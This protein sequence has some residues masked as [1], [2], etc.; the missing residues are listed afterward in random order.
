MSAINY[1]AARGCLLLGWILLA[2]PL[3][4]QGAGRSG[5]SALQ[6]LLV[7]EDARGYGVDG[8]TPLV[9]GLR[10][11]DSLFRRVAVR[12]IGRLQ[13]PDLAKLLVPM[14]R[15]PVAAV[16]AEAA[17][18]IAQ[19]LSGTGRASAAVTEGQLTPRAA[20]EAILGRLAQEQD[21]YVIDALAEALGR[22]PFADSTEARSAEAAMHRR[23]EGL[24]TVGIVRGMYALTMNRRVTGGL[25]TSGI[26]LLRQAALKSSDPETRR[27]SVLTLGLLNGLDSTTT[28]R[29]SR[30]ADE[31][32]RRLA[33]AGKMSVGLPARIALVQRALADPSVIVRIDAVRAAR[34]LATVPDCAPIVAATRDREPYVALIAIDAL[35]GAC[36]DSAAARAALA[37]IV[38]RPRT[39]GGDHSWQAPSRALL[40]LVRADPARAAVRLG[41]FAASSRWQER[42]VAARVAALLAQSAVL[43][44]LA[45]DADQNVREAAIAGL[46]ATTK[47]A[48]DS[49]F[50]AGLAAPGYQVVLAS[51]E[52]LAGSTSPK[53]LPAL[54]DA[55]DAVTAR[56]SENARDPRLAILQRIGEMG[57]RE[58][59]DRLLPYL[60]DFDTTVAAT[61]ATLLSKWSGNA[62]VARPVPLPIQTEPLAQIFTA[63]GMRLR[64]TLAQSSGGGSFTIALYSDVAPATVARMLR[65]VRAHYFDGLTIQRVEP[66][67]VIQGGSPGATEYIGDTSFMRDE[68][69]TLSHLRGTV[70]I[71]SRGRDTGDAQFFVNL[72]D[73]P[74]LDHDYTVFGG[75]I[76]GRSVAERVMEGDTIARIE[77]VGSP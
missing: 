38:D 68:L 43:L 51:A 47:H 1:V 74:R 33:L 23:V 46:A 55:L 19:G 13:R 56:R 7:A 58:T 5:S 39:N 54:L 64:V 25:S 66:N 49:V 67:F 44:Q 12:G 10:S 63:K 70:G 29:A 61:A 28:F 53:A 11:G 69:S 32:V 4:A 18:A 37:Q 65:L 48:A 75:I 20:Q 72:V 17:N 22:L 59:I 24:P 45:A 21:S 76:A 42:A 62:V 26:G 50:I 73:N 34:S 60:A 30:D 6:R 3:H 9:E 16:R 52:A 41:A 71:S 15:D 2:S 40:A 35:S 77:V 8:I 36:A 27:L 57:S 14:L 31:Q